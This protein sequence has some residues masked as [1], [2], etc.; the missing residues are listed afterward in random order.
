MF[1]T[2]H[3]L[4]FFTVALAI[5][6]CSCG[7][8]TVIDFEDLSTVT[9]TGSFTP[10]TPGTQYPVGTTLIERESGIQLMVLPFKNPSA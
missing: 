10:V 7:T 3:A 2:G 4:N 9:P 8:T 1:K 6:L 5:F